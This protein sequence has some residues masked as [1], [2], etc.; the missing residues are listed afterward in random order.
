MNTPDPSPFPFWF[1]FYFIGLWLFVCA[2]FAFISGWVFLARR[3]R[4][5]DRPEGK[6]VR[7]QVKQIGFISERQVTHMIVS[8]SGLYLYESFLFRFLHPP[9][10]IPWSDVRLLKE[11]KTLWW[12]YYRIDLG[13]IA[14]IT[15]TRKAYEEIRGYLTKI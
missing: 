10:L 14:S 8:H 13:S 9:L 6:K 2:L 7:S 4:A 3:Y 5:S 12:Y 15:V 1:P 11:F